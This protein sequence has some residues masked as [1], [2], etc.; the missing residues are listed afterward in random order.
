M[1]IITSWK[2]FTGVWVTASYLQSPGFVSVFR[3][4][5]TMLLSG[6]FQFFLWF[7][8]PQVFLPSLLGPFQLYLL[9]LVSWSHSC[10]T[11]FLVLWQV[12]SLCLSFCC[13]FIFTVYQNGK[14]H[15]TTNSILL[16]SA[17]S[18]LL[19]GIRWSI[20]IS[21]FQRISWISFIRMHSGL[22]T[23]H[24]VVWSKFMYL[25]NSQWIN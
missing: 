16:I 22:C 1:I 3:L 6:W 25:H 19:D 24:L 21:K 8:I 14:I 5:S 13:L 15:K 23:Y 10:S 2:S 12:P 11:A 17:R 18:G 9:Q 4:I 7:P 20:C